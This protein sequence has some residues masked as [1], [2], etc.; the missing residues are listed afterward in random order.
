MKNKESPY[1]EIRSLYDWIFFIFMS[2]LLL[3]K[4]QIIWIGTVEI[5]YVTDSVEWINTA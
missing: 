1:Q 3:I 2:Q 5:F 4:T